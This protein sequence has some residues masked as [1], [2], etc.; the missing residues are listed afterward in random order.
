MSLEWRARCTKSRLII[1]VPSIRI[2]PQTSCVS[3]IK[4]EGRQR[5]PAY[6]GHVTAVMRAALARVQLS[7]MINSSIRFLFTGGQVG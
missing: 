2:T 6:V 7:I 3:A 4:V 5:S 1:F